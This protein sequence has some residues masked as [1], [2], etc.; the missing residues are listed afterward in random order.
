MKTIFELR[1]IKTK[2]IIDVYENIDEVLKDR[3]V[4]QYVTRKEVD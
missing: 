4:S 3:E 2:E 1:D